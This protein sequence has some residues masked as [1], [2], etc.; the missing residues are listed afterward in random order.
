MLLKEAF[1]EDVISKILKRVAELSKSG[2]K[3]FDE[4]IGDFN[5]WSA[6]DADGTV[7][8]CEPNQNTDSGCAAVT[9]SDITDE[10][11]DDIIQDVKSQL[12]ESCN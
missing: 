11:M 4:T 10:N 3:S 8:I 6:D 2:N 12:T 5:F 9:I 7:F 1:S